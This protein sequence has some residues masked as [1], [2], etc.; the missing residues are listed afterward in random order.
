MSRQLLSRDIAVIYIQQYEKIRVEV[1]FIKIVYDLK[2]SRLLT[3]ISCH[4][5]FD[6]FIFHWNLKSQWYRAMFVTFLSKSEPCVHAWAQSMGTELAHTKPIQPIVLNGF[7]AHWVGEVHKHYIMHKYLLCF[8][9]GRIHIAAL[10]QWHWAIV[11]K[12]H[13]FAPAVIRLQPGKLWVN[14]T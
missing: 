7:N 1:L 4:I 6:C 5:Q 9:I 8:D 14:Q 10:Y 11:Q 12:I 2:H 13:D 3:M